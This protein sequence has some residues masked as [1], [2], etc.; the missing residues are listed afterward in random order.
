MRQLAAVELR[1]RIINNDGAMWLLVPSAQRD[2]IKQK[3]L[4]IVGTEVK[5]VHH[6]TDCGDPLTVSQQARSAPGRSCYGRHCQ[7]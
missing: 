5:C 1:K 4:E 2:E 6:P 3:M 7:H